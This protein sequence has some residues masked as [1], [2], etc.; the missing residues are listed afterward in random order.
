MIDEQML[1]NYAHTGNTNEQPC[2]SPEHAASIS[3]NLHN[4]VSFLL[5]GLKFSCS[6]AKRYRLALQHALKRFCGFAVVGADAHLAKVK[7]A[8]GFDRVS[9][10][11]VMEAKPEDD[12]RCLNSAIEGTKSAQTLREHEAAVRQ[13]LQ[14]CANLLAQT[15]PLL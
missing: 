10:A 4:S 15:D 8:I 3:L 5:L 1:V 13:Q 6:A 11:S 9:S 12:C 14:W 7:T 2:Q